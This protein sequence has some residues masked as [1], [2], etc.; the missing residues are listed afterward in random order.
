MEAFG[1][2]VAVG[3]EAGEEGTAEVRGCADG[4]FGDAF[5]EDLVLGWPFSVGGTGDYGLVRSMVKGL[6]GWV[7]GLVWVGETEVMMRG[8]ILLVRMEKD[9]SVSIY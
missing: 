3:G 1:A 7:R 6:G 9:V 5:V 8:W 2:E 4:A